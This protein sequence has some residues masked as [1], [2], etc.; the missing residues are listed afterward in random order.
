MPNDQV[1]DQNVFAFMM[2]LVQE[3][4][5][6]EVTAEFLNTE[7]DKLYDTFGNNL[8]SYFEPMLSEEQR[9]EFNQLINSGQDQQ[10]MLEF[11]VSAIPNLEEQIL[12]V[13]VS[14]RN[15]YLA[16]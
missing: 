1:K 14:F 13:L 6:D 11:L 4:H 15:E 8:V 16:N 5:G 7:S 12:Q 2:Q 9:S 10:K 3:K